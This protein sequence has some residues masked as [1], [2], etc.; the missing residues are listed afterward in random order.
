MAFPIPQPAKVRRDMRT[1]SFVL[2]NGNGAGDQN[3]ADVTGMGVFQFKVDGDLEGDVA[4]E[5]QPLS[6]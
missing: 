4:E 6:Y 2:D 3:R 1:A 5:P